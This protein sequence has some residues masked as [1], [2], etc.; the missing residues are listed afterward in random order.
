[1]CRN[2][3]GANPARDFCPTAL[4]FILSALAAAGAAGFGRW[5]RPELKWLAWFL[6]LIAT[7]KLLVQDLRHALAFGMVLSLL[8]YGAVLIW[9]PRLMRTPARHEPH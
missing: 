8:V 1:M 2:A 6:A 5:Q 7:Y 3:A 4:T 9:L